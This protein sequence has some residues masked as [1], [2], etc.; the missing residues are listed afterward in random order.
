[1]KTA[2][3]LLREK[4]VEIKADGLCKGPMGSLC[5]C[6]LD[7]LLVCGDAPEK[8]VPAKNNPK[9]AKKMQCNYWME[10]ME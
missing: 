5:G 9:M 2:V 3:D 7:L 10:P 4:L 6:S 8:C 1:M